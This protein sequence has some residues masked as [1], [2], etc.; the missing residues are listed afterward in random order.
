[1]EIWLIAGL[2]GALL[3]L[4]GIVIWLASKLAGSKTK[5]TKQVFSDTAEKDVQ[6]I[7]NDTFRQELRNRGILHFEQIINENAM[8]LQQDLRLTASQVNDYMKQE[9]KKTLTEEFAKYEQS[10]TDAKQ[11][12]IESINK[13]QQAI[14]D[15]RKILTEQLK[16]QS[17]TA[18]AQLI[19][20]FEENMADIVNHYIM[21]AIG[22]QIDL[23]DQ[24]EYII[25]DLEANK[26]AIV[27]DI[28]SGA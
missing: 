12:A 26:K 5:A 15:Q 24:L 18:K 22:D 11:L 14:E 7:F 17:D 20:Q 23:S 19:A 3:I 16:Q 27:E 8:F 4:L 28:T 2:G 6:H 25:G 21:A 1:M 10:I 13:T 9:I